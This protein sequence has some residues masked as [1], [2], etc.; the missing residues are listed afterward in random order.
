MNCSEENILF[1]DRTSFSLHSAPK[2][3]FLTKKLS[4]KG[5]SMVIGFSWWQLSTGF[6]LFIAC[7]CTI[8]RSLARSFYDSRNLCWKG[9]THQLCI[10]FIQWQKTF[11]KRLYK[12]TTRHF[13]WARL[14]SPFLIRDTHIISEQTQQIALR[15]SHVGIDC[16]DSGTWNTTVSLYNTDF[17]FN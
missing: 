4:C 11:W 16:D 15:A 7:R 14:H 3:K 10:E 5:F 12:E 8:A 13:S 2:R 6:S 9:Y 1:V 17:N